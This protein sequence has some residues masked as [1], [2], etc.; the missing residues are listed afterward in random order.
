M[1]ATVPGYVAPISTNGT[2]TVVMPSV[3]ERTLQNNIPLNFTPWSIGCCLGCVQPDHLWM[4]KGKIICPNAERP[5]VNASAAK[6][7]VKL[8]ELE[9]A[10]GKNRRKNKRHRAMDWDK[11]GTGQKA[12]F[13]KALV[14]KSADFNDYIKTAK[15]EDDTPDEKPPP[16]VTVLPSITVLN[17]CAGSAPPPSP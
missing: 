10:G 8:R 6:N 17:Y 12:K 2:G 1:L 16:D 5:G 13:A 15:K 9:S 4:K 11:L 14:A 7:L 3:A